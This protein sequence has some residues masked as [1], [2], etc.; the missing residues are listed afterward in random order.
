MTKIKH[1]RYTLYKLLIVMLLAAI[2]S[3]FVVIGNFIIPLIAF[4]IASVLMFLLKKSTDETLTDERIE[5]IAGRASRLVFVI[6]VLIMALAGM[7]LIA[8]RNTYPQY[9]TIGYTLSYFGCGM[10]FL[11]S[12]LFKYYSNKKV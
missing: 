3:S 6:S 4:L 2:V 5:K 10:M 9:S 12:I 1:K 8:L 7:V 11:Y